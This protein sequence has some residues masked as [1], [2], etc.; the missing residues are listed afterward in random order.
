MKLGHK[1]HLNTQNKIPKEIFPNP[2]ISFSILDELE[3]LGFG[4]TRRN[5][6]NQR[7][8]AMDSLQD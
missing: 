4:V 1:G 3:E 8:R 2:K 7:A 6:P 5:P